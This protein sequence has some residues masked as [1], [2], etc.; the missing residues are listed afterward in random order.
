MVLVSP[1]GPYGENLRAEGFSWHTFDFTR[2]GTNP[3]TELGTVNR[4]RKLYQEIS[5]DIAHHFTV[6]C[7]LYGGI[8][9]RLL[10]IPTVSAVTGTGHIF[11][12]RSLKN[13]ALRPLIAA[14]YRY[15]FRNSQVIFQNPDDLKTFL[16]LG[17]CSYAHSHLIRGSGVNVDQFFPS[18]SPAKS[19]NQISVILVC[20]LLKEKGVAEFV[21]AAE[22]V[23]RHHRE[24]TFLIAGEPDPGNPSSISQEQMREWK[25]ANH[26]TFLGHQDDMESLLRE[27]AICVLPSYYGEGVPR[28]L[29][30]AAASGLPLVTTDMPG[31]REI[32]R[33][34]ENGLLVSPRD[35][36]ALASAITRLIVEPSTR[37]IMG[38]RSRQ[39]AVEEFSER[40]VLKETLKVY[41]ASLAAIELVK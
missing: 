13:M 5:P 39:I 35:A 32:C 29:I 40:S 18:A 27:S 9:A 16:R 12:T 10:G 26:V 28:S 3:F 30:E 31:C 38:Q 20:R 36:L 6:K 41:D 8:V 15:A 37:A 2:K 25:A 21:E 11:T 7:V 24:T 33:D 22:I 23:R 4:L 34:G 14:G 19:D 17:L 1:P